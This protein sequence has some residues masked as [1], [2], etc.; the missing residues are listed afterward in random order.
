MPRIRLWATVAL[1]A[2]VVAA[3]FAVIIIG[4]DSKAIKD[5]RDIFSPLPDKTNIIIAQLSFAIVE[6]LLCFAFIGIYIAV[7]A[8][9]PNR[10]RRAQRVYVR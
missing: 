4:L 8:L 6:L 10:L 5:A 7:Q 3:C 1:I 2:T 9:A